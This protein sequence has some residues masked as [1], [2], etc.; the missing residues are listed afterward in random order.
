MNIK[1]FKDTDTLF[2]CLNENWIAETHDIREDILVERDNK[3]KL[4]S[5][6]LE[7]ASKQAIMKDF[8]FQEFM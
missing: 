2:V 7:H 6:T 3:G 1:Y 8:L 5:M 4:V